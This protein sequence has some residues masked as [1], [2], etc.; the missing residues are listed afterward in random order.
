M[1]TS[2]ATVLSPAGTWEI[3]PS[4]SSV[5]FSARHLMV[6]KV[7]GRFSSFHGTIVVPADPLQSTV[8][9]V[10][11][12]ASIDT[13]DDNRDTHL[14]SADF[15]DVEKYPTITFVSTGVSGLHGETF[16]LS[17]NLT[18]KEVT[19]LVELEVEFNGVQQDPWGGTR[20]GFDAKTEFSRKDFGLEWNVA[21]DGGGVLVG[22]KVTIELE[23]EAVKKADETK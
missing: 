2:E 20:A 9:V 1:S 13:R 17:G 12:T 6:S 3:D 8:N 14:K 10:I 7:R 15:A 18:I 23:I 16:T 4:H 5:N 11:D 21:L 19:N 22:D